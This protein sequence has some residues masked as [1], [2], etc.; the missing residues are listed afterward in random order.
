MIIKHLSHSQQLKLYLKT[1]FTI[2]DW[3]DDA[4]NAGRVS[5]VFTVKNWWRG[6]EGGLCSQHLNL[7][8]VLFLLLVWLIMGENITGCYSPDTQVRPVRDMQSRWDRRQG[9]L[10]TGLIW[11]FTRKLLL[12]LLECWWWCE[13]TRTSLQFNSLLYINVTINWIQW[14]NICNLCRAC[15]L[16]QG[17]MRLMW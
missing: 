13:T 4:G 10:T 3:L 8:A 11:S 12:F 1:I 9:G 6:S 5:V 2:I 15:T 16:W 14:D 17:G 7:S